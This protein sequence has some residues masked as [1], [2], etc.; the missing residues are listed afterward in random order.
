MSKVMVCCPKCHTVSDE[1]DMEKRETDLVTYLDFECGMCGH[2]WVARALNMK[3][4]ED[5]TK[6]KIWDVGL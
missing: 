6:I 5:L 1:G 3:P 2:R 4:A